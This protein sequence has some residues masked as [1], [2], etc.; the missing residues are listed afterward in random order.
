MC[1]DAMPSSAARQ[2]PHVRHPCACYRGARR[3]EAVPYFTKIAS[4]LHSGWISLLSTNTRSNGHCAEGAF[5]SFS[6]SVQNISDYLALAFGAVSFV[7]FVSCTD[8]GVKLCFSSCSFAKNS[9]RANACRQLAGGLKG[10]YFS[11]FQ[12]SLVSSI[13]SR[14]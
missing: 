1:K 5:S 10:G 6:F 9:S 8:Y 4:F 7:L 14:S 12:L 13:I 2:R 3:I 11:R